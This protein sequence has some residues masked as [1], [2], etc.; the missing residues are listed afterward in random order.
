MEYTY[1]IDPEFLK[2]VLECDKAI[3]EGKQPTMECYKIKKSKKH[4][5]ECSKKCICK[6]IK[7]AELE[8]TP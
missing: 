1:K 4:S 6:F 8:E 7:W 3:K 2:R 5:N